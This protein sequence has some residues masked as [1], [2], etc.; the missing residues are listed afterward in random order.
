MARRFPAIRLTGSYGHASRELSNM[1]TAGSELWSLAS[2]L[3]QSIFYA[4]NLR[5]GQ[6]AAEARFRQGLADYAKT[7]LTAFSEVE[8][9]LLTRKQRLEQRRRTLVAL[10]EAV[11][12][13]QEAESRYAQGLV[14]YLNVITTQTVRFN[15]EEQLVLIDLAILSNR[16]TLHRVLG[17][18]WDGLRPVMAPEDGA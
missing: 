12:A 17:G 9:A 16:V 18:G 8:G 10:K 14:D 13:Q 3:S 2:G 5:A 6:R 15:I 4:G 1:F 11:A 7:V